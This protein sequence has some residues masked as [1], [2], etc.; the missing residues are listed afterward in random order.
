MAR[1]F[2]QTT[3]SPAVVSPGLCS[4][5]TRER[6]ELVQ[7][8]TAN[9]RACPGSAQIPLPHASAIHRSS[10]PV[11]RRM[12][13]A[14]TPVVCSTAPRSTETPGIASGHARRTRGLSLAAPVQYKAAVLTSIMKGQKPPLPE[15]A[16][17]PPLAPLSS[18]LSTPMP[19]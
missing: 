10:S 18:Q 12:H 8:I 2:V 1:S 9:T 15:T 14:Y 5:E 6:D 4:S 16:G 7:H 19:R 17:P 13:T 11:K 3:A